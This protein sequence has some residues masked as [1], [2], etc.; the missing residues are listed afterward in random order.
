MMH[1]LSIMMR[2]LLLHYKDEHE[3]IV[4]TCS[5]P[6][7]PLGWQLSGC[8]LSWVA[9]VLVA[10]VRGRSYPGWELSG[11]GCLSGTCAGGS[12][13]D[14]QNSGTVSTRTRLQ[15]GDVTLV[16]RLPRRKR[17]RFFDNFGPLQ[18]RTRK[19]VPNKF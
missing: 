4:G 13:P 5:R 9:V 8:Q 2:S 14:T 18:S 12:C 15:T 19:Y 1:S 17:F 3:T 6:T 7:I 11:G 10:V 16:S